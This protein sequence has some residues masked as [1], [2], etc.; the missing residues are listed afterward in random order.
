MFNI[1]VP[2]TIFILEHST[3]GFE[4]VTIDLFA[5]TL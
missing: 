3:I 4:N 1:I 5:V 2:L